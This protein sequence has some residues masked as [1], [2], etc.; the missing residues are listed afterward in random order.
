MLQ[1]LNRR[2]V[3]VALVG[4]ITLFF[5]GYYMTRDEEFYLLIVY[6]VLTFLLLSIYPIWKSGLIPKLGFKQV[7]LIGLLFRLVL[8]FSVPNL[9][10]DYFRFIWDGE[11]NF[12]WI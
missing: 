2:T 10:D 1:L 7:L 12:K 3:I 5:F 8:L 11:L 6:S 4:I 9:S